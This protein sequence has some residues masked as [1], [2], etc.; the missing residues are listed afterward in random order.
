MRPRTTNPYGRL[1]Q[2]VQALEASGLDGLLPSWTHFS[3]QTR[4]MTLVGIE[5]FSSSSSRPAAGVM[6]EFLS[7]LHGVASPI[8]TLTHGTP[9]RLAFHAGFHGGSQ[10]H[11]AERLHAAWPGASIAPATSAANSLLDSLRLPYRAFLSGN[12]S[13]A[14]L[15]STGESPSDL[16]ARALPTSRWAW[17]TFLHPVAPSNIAARL[18]QL[19]TELQEVVSAFLRPG[20]TEENNNPLARRYRHLLEAAIQKTELGLTT[21]LWETHSALLADSEGALHSGAQA[22]LAALAGDDSLPQPIR[23]QSATPAADGAATPSTLL[24]SQEAALFT[25][26]PTKEQPGMVVRPGVRFDVAPPRVASEHCFALGPILDESRAT[27]NWFTGEVDWLASHCLITGT[28]GSGKTTTAHLLLRQLTENF[29]I[30]WLVIEPSLKAEYRTLLGTPA[31]RHLLIYTAGNEN[32]SPLRINPLEVPQG[33]PVQSHIDSLVALFTAAFAWVT[34][35][36]YI[37]AQALQRTYENAGWNLVTG[38]H[39]GASTVHPTLSDLLIAVE[40]VARVSGY[41]AEITA[42]IRAGIGTRLRGLTTGA[43]GCMFD[44]CDGTDFTRILAQPTIIE[45]SAIGSDEEKSFLLGLL[46]LRISQIRQAE[47]MSGNGLRH[48][49]VIEE[50]HRLLRAVPSSASMET[51]S[52]AAK[53][54]EMFSHL[55]SE[56]RAY[57]Q[58]IMVLEQIPSKLAPDVIKN[59][60]LK[61]IHRLSGR[62]DREAVGGSAGLSQERMDYLAGLRNGE[63]VAALASERTVCHV[64]LPDHRKQFLE[65][66]HLPP[67]P[68]IREHMG[69]LGL[70]ASSIPAAGV[71]S[72]TAKIEA[73]QCRGCDSMACPLRSRALSAL[74][75]VNDPAAFDSALASGWEAVFAFGRRVAFQE[76]RNERMPAEAPHCILMNLAALLG[77]SPESCAK[78]HRNLLIIMNNPPGN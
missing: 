2:G 73:P 24:P 47:G 29:G 55:L 32:V 51:A 74:T 68:T 31:G 63:A 17:L 28:T 54:V 59:T 53:A 42:N 40:E 9:G 70:L 25:A 27:P 39:A 52:P 43:K 37:L 8:C 4:G 72:R 6:R 61:I 60:N 56:V 46:L 30:P 36:P 7:G 76:W 23:I 65:P 67:D 16:L 22:L 78:L 15:T 1:A 64:R 58:G 77:W 38:R 50:A 12:P 33:T 34:P 45:L 49:L 41:D 14:R 71:P 69:N 11:W 62:D 18:H 48:M 57:G 3:E 19:R 75:R 21:G 5:G 10:R 20:T 13:L 66:L 35:L 26:P 44:C